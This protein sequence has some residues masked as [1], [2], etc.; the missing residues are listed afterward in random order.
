ERYDQIQLELTLHGVAEA[1][2]ATH[3][4]FSVDRVVVDPDL[5]QQ[6][7]DFCN[8]LSLVGDA[9]TWNTLLF[10][11]RKAGQL[12]QIPGTRRT[13]FSWEDCDDFMFASEIAWQSMLND[14]AAVSLDEILCDPALGA[15]LDRRAA[16]LAPGRTSLEYRWAALKLRK[17][18]KF[19]RGRAAVLRPPTAVDSAARID[20]IVNT[21]L[22]DQPGLY[23]LSDET[24]KEF[25]VG[26]TLNLN[27]QLSQVCDRSQ[28][29]TALSDSVFVQTIPMDHTSAGRLAWK[30]CLISKKLEHCPRLNYFELR[31]V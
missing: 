13:N 29:W 12:A 8:R 24:Q 28:Q 30:S 25:Y 23:I 27:R 1:Y 3:D 19:A 9:R 7:V 11:L 2:V 31:V 21:S 18:A 15:E 20:E 26:E 5:N 17:E 6:F 16:A 4:G 14:N 10:R 22:T